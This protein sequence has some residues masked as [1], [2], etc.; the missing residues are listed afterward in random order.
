MNA[1]SQPL[2]GAK[3]SV[4][5]RPPSCRAARPTRGARVAARAEAKNI[6]ASAGLAP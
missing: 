4:A 1:T 5:A 3:A 6:G 2:A